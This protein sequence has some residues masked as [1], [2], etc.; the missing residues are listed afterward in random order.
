MSRVYHYY[1]AASI[2]PTKED[3]TMDINVQRSNV[4]KDKWKNTRQ[5]HKPPT[6]LLSVVWLQ[7]FFQLYINIRIKQKSPMK[8]YALKVNICNVE[9]ITCYGYVW[10]YVVLKDCAPRWE[11]CVNRIP[12]CIHSKVLSQ[13]CTICYSLLYAKP[14]ETK[15]WWNP[16]ILG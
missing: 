6:D 9:I 3:S 5:T 1:A 8:G 10:Y 13:R 14:R 16:I 7:R 11:K 12:L 15:H 2:D 4:K